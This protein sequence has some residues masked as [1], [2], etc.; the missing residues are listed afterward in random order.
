MQIRFAIVQGEPESELESGAESECESESERE[1]QGQHS[2]SNLVARK[3]LFN[4]YANS[5]TD[6]DAGANADCHPDTVT[7]AKWHIHT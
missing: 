5:C 1:S 7:Y 4:F 3:Y 2:N 6:T